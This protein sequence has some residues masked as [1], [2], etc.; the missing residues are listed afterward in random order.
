MPQ[1][2]P[3]EA[4]NS[5]SDFKFSDDTEF[6]GIKEED[7]TPID[8]IVKEVKGTKTPGDDKAPADVTDL[9]EKNTNQT[10]DE[11]EDDDEEVTFFEDAPEGDSK[12]KKADEKPEPGKPPKNKQDNKAKKDAGAGDTEDTKDT[13]DVGGVEDEKEEDFYTELVNEMKEKGIFQNIKLEEGEEITEERFVELQ[14]EEIESRVEETLEALFENLD[15]DAKRFIQF[16]K[17]GG[18]T[19]AFLS[20][21]T[22]RFD[23]KDFDENEEKHQQ[24]VLKHYLTNYEQLDKEDLQDRLDWLKETGKEKSYAKKYYQAIKAEELEAE[25][26]LLEQ[27]KAEAEAKEKNAKTFNEGIRQVMQKTETVGVFPITKADKVDLDTYITKPVVKVDKN[28]YIPQFQLDISKI[29]RAQ[30]EE[31]KQK[32]IVLAKLVKNNFDIADLKANTETE[33]VKRVKSKLKEAKTGVR[34][35]SSNRNGEKSLSDYFT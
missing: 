3:T 4:S 21:V 29:F 2:K 13:G 11:D 16:K 33:V 17:N 27:T 5:L 30:T 25:K 18:N 22:N 10:K 32:L 19:E 6:F 23:I 15:D 26:E 8:K 31:D 14:D 35:H 12:D 9:G 20:L 28:R 1:I 34:M 24:V 7:I